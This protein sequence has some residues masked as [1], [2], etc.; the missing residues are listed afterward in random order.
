[1]NFRRL[2]GAQSR[3][4]SEQLHGCMKCALLLDQNTVK[5][6]LRGHSQE[7]DNWPLKVA[8]HSFE[9]PMPNSP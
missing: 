4:Q 8:E 9:E 5:P 6:L 7:Q 3:I 2:D 1:M